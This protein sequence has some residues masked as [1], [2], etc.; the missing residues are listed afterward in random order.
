M[1]PSISA[2]DI[3]NKCIRELALT[4]ADDSFEARRRAN[5]RSRDNRAMVC[6]IPKSN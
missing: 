1:L 6:V 3:Y 5:S 4:Q 2:T